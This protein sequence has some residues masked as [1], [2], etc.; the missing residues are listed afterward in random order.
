MTRWLLTVVADCPA[1]LFEPAGERRLA[2]EAVAPD[3]SSSSVFGTSRSRLATRWASTSSTCGSTWTTCRRGAARTGRGR[4]RNPRSGKQYSSGSGSSDDGVSPL[5]TRRSFPCRSSSANLHDRS[6]HRRQ[7]FVHCRFRD[8]LSTWPRCRRTA[9]ARGAGTGPCPGNGHDPHPRRD[10]S[11][12]A[13]VLDLGS[14]VGDVALA[15]AN[16]VG[17]TG[18]VLGIDRSPSALAVARERTERARLG[19]IEF[20]EGDLTA[21]A[22][23]G[24]FD[25]VVGRLV[26]STSRIRRR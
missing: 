3:P 12:H 24:E 21:A 25:A 1:R 8:Q 2:D 22:I 16:R 4:A 11:G 18:S 10:R 23:D 6:K 15:V 17:P 5:R 7:R 26:F 20:V 14:G 13:R 19:N 9:A